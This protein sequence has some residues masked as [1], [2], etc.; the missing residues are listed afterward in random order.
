[1]SIKVLIPGGAGFIG[2]HVG[3]LLLDA[4]HQVTVLDNLSRGHRDA[5]DRRAGF[6]QADLADIPAVTAALGGHDAVI[7]MAA[8]IEVNESVANPLLFAENNIMNSVRLCEAM[9]T[10]GVKKIVFSSSATVYGVPKRL[11]IQEDDPTVAF[12]PYGATKLAMEACLSAYHYS[13][14][15]DVILLRYF[16]PYGP[17]ERHQPE[18]H[19]I[20]NFIL[21]ALE[22]RPVPLYWKGEQVRD[23]IYIDDL[24]RAHIEALALSGLNVFNV[25][26]EHGVRVIEVLRAIEKI[27][28]KRLEIEDRGERAGD[29]PANYASYRKLYGATGW[30]PQVSLEEGLGRTIE[31]FKRR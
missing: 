12:N 14:G 3:R 22:G 26:T 21:A 10:A 13:F 4:G 31:Y 24:A 20:P 28:G 19:A 11:P 8:F 27:V 7:H 6:V 25:G 30:R 1:M 5:V 29:V 15:F 16:N 23:F 18:S 2:S 17:G 9:R